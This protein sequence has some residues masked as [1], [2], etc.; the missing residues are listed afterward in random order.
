MSRR[1]A[2]IVI[3]AGAAVVGTA[4]VLRRRALNRAEYDSNDVSRTEPDQP[5][6]AEEAVGSALLT[7]QDALESAFG[8][9]MGGEPNSNVT[10]AR[11]RSAIGH[12]I[13]Y[14]MGAGQGTP[15][16][17]D[18]PSNTGECDCTQFVRW[19]NRKKKWVGS[20]WMVEDANGK[21]TEYRRIAKPVPGCVVV[22]PG[23]AAILSDPA[24]LTV[25]DCSKSHNGISEHEAPYFASKLKT[26][27]AIYCQPV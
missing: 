4:W 14:R 21:Q 3:V 24:T 16:D 15:V 5:T 12:G 27:E 23:H 6:A 9:W 13:K 2:P 10:L 7:T 17:F 11:A 26:G 8:G 18:L 25:I 20:A 1:I 22:Y 19:V